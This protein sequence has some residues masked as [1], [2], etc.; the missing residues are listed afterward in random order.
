MDGYQLA[1][2]GYSDLE[3]LFV[4]EGGNVRIYRFEDFLKGLS[5]EF[6]EVLLDQFCG[7]V[8]ALSVELLLDGFL[9]LLNNFLLPLVFGSLQGSEHF[10]GKLVDLSLSFL[11]HQ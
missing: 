8:S 2:P 10:F 6:E 1:F 5:V 11:K 9:E 3:L 7:L 4:D